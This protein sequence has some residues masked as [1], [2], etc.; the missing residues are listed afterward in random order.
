MG[1]SF[2]AYQAIA[3]RFAGA[4]KSDPANNTIRKAHAAK[5]GA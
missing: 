1:I 5:S 3:A 4:S 2:P